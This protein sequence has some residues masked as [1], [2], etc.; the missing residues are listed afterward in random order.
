MEM[1]RTHTQ[2]YYSGFNWCFNQTKQE[3]RFKVLENEVL[4]S[5]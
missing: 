2:E 4:M 5:K 3:I 1:Y